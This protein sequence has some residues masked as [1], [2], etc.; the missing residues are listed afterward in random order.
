LLSPNPLV[1]Y[2]NILD[3]VWVTRQTPWRDVESPGIATLNSP[4]MQGAP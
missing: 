1:G 4:F 2:P 3:G